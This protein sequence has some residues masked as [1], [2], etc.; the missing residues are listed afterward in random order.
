[1]AAA[2]KLG[3]TPFTRRR[4]VLIVFCGENLKFGSVGR[5]VAA[6]LGETLR[7][8]AAADRFT[9]K[10]GSSLDV[11]APPGL[12]VPRVVVIGTGKQTA[13]TSRDLIKLGGIATDKLPKTASAATIVAELASRALKPDQVANLALGARLR[14]Y[15]FDRYKTKRKEDDEQRPK[16]IELSF[17]CSN[18]A[19]AEKAWKGRGAVADG[20]VLA[21][22]LINEPANVLYPGEFA[23]RT[24]ALSKLGIVAEV[25]DVAAMR[26]L[27]MGALLGVGQGAAHEAKLVVMRW[28]GGKRGVAPI[29]FIGKGVCFDSG[30]LSI[31]PAQGMED[32]KG[33]MAGAACV[34]GLMHALAAR[35]A[36]VNVVG[37]IGLVENMPDGKAQRPGDIVTTM[38]GQT[39]EIINTDA[40]G[41]LVLAD[42]LHY[43]KKRFKPK[44][45]VNLAT[46]TGAIVVA[47]GHEY[48][49]LFSNDDKLAE[50]LIQAGEATGERVWRMPLAAEY[51]KMIDSKFADMKNTGGRSGGAITA[52]QLLQRFVD[53]TPWAHLDI[54]GTGLGS[55]QS[56]INKS[57]ASGWGVQLL[58]RLVEDHYER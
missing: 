31:K 33:D 11:M 24:S 41:R 35:R 36:K 18:P 47:L 37:A 38:S 28:N 53:K 42:V 27:G 26:K 48:A 9:G 23:R 10:A 50:L 12:D 3:F 44:L 5:R 14:A 30:G 29:A 57:W 39:I 43:V 19:S 13:P 34:V 55:P 25:L 45:M 58:E 1:M 15:T 32:M 16:S 4:G 21:R 49:G 54:A 51:D 46:L 40:E 2:L 56:D 52:A 6:E 17:A 20:I 8:A 22:D 7:R